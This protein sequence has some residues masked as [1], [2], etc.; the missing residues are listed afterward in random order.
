MAVAQSSRCSGARCK[1]VANAGVWI[2]RIEIA[3]VIAT[4]T[5]AVPLCSRLRLAVSIA[6]ATVRTASAIALACS[7]SRPTPRLRSYPPAT[8]KVMSTPTAPMMHHSL[9]A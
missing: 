8:I 5:R 1:R 9:A 4:V 6:L 7:T 2:K 3:S